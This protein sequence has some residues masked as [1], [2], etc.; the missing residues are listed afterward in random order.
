MAAAISS[1]V[2]VV[3]VVVLVL[4]APSAASPSP[5]LSPA[6]LVRNYQN[7]LSNFKIFVYT[8]PSNSKPFDS[9]FPAAS[10]F[11]KSLLR[12]RFVTPDPAQA[13]LFFVPFSPHTSARSLGRIIRD[14]RSAYPYWNRTLGADHFFL[15][16]V[17][18]DF[19]S[20]RNVLELKKNSIQISL[21][22]VVSGLFIPHKDITLPPLIPPRRTPPPENPTAPPSIL[23]YL[24]W[25]GTR[26]V[27][28]VSQ[29]KGDPDFLV[30]ELKSEG[31]GQE[32][33]R[34]S[35]S[36][37][38]CLF[39]YGGGEAAWAWAVEAMRE[40]CVPAV[41]VERPIQDLP[42]MD[43]LRWCDMAVVV[44]GGRVKEVLSG[45]S[46][47]KWAEMRE[48]GMAVAAKHLVWNAVAEEGAAAMDVFHMV[49]YQLWQRRHVVRY[50]RRELSML[51]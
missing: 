43:V 36:S 19:S 21:F 38:F 37:R 50:A 11:Y 5:Y 1:V 6:T 14:L 41:I 34:R 18:I 45:V 22:P 27:N 13:H 23:G 17:G 15:S 10:L 42:L 47:E 24:R 32:V 7:M 20:D 31:A 12:S 29:M 16:P 49:M 26:G 2:V 9:R 25:D 44:E 48:V 40:G 51:D 8:H 46:E 28:F 39:V 30:E 3:L 4:P 33:L 35:R